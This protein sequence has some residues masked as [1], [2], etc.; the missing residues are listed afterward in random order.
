VISVLIL[1]KNEENNIIDCLESASFADEL[2]VI[3]D[4]S[5]DRTVQLIKSY[6]HP[7]I[8]VY[9]RPLNQNFS[10]QRNFGL[11]KAT[12]EWVLFLDADE[13]IPKEL[14]AEIEQITQSENKY[15]SYMIKRVDTLW[16][17]QLEYGETGNI[18]LLRLARKSS[19]IWMGKVHEE[20]KVKGKVGTLGN[21]LFHYP[22]QSIKDFLSEVDY[23]STI[24]A[25]ELFDQ[26]VKTSWWQII[27]YPK[28]KFFV[29]YVLK[30][31]YK[32]GVS[33]FLI[34]SMMSFHSFLVR[35]KLYLLWKERGK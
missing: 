22:H 3:D 11:A 8:R 30:K 12:G 7:F 21:P 10:E 16:G 27:L 23:Y 18:M 26:K 6:G 24:R 14:I 25:K 4:E 1:T 15:A 34:A 5:S 13:Q 19:G 28:A 31:G 33:G 17:K 29:N 2:I 9:S 32:D 35:G 20:W